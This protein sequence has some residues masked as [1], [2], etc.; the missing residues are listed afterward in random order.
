MQKKAVGGEEMSEYKHPCGD[1]RHA[2]QFQHGPDKTNMYPY[3]RHDEVSK[4]KS[5]VILDGKKPVW[6][7]LKIKTH[8]IKSKY[9]DGL[10]DTYCGKAGQKS[11]YWK[12]VDC[13]ECVF[14]QNKGKA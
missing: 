11:F 3:C 12:E 14:Q 6:C 13:E 2:D 1:C 8:K 7:P 9:N 5:G 4:N 10:F